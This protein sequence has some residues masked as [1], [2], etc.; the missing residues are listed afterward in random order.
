MPI[1]VL[2]TYLAGSGATLLGIESHRGEI[3]VRLLLALALTWAVGFE[4]ELRGAA[5][6]DRTFALVGVGS[7]LV[8]YLSLSGAPHALAGVLTGIGFVGGGVI[9]GN[10]SDE[11]PD[12]IHGITTA[13][14]LFLVASVGMAAGRG[15]LLLATFAAGA[16]LLLLEIRHQ[17]WLR[18]LDGRTWRRNPRDGA[19]HDNGPPGS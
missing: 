9:F 3:V 17:R 6:G 5:A 18:I 10:P 12:K 8:G 11:Y 13:A 1:A 14:A 2:T 15:E 4:R 19:T 16:G 7:A